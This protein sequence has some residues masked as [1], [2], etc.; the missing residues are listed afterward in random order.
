MKSIISIVSII[1]NEITCVFRTVIVSI[2]SNEITCVFRT[3]IVSIISIISITPACTNSKTENITLHAGAGLRDAADELIQ[4]FEKENPNIKINANY[5]GSGRLLGQII[6]GNLGGLFMPGDVFYVDQAIKKGA[7][8]E[9]TKNKIAYFVPVIFVQKG[10]PK[11]IYLLK[12]LERKNVRIGLGDERIAA[13]GKRTLKIFEKNKI[14][15][16]KIK[17][18][19]VVKTA[20]V[21]ELGIAIAAKTVDVVILW[22]VIARQFT[23]SGDIISI[24]VSENII[25][26]IPIVM[27]KPT[28][29]KSA[30]Q[31]FI[32]FCI[33]KKGKEILKEKGYNVN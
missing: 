23:K 3:V 8:I 18:Q 16:D 11:N 29:N 21:N 31:K 7:A 33:S 24:P 1:S 30:A 12:N 32:D 15:Y 22:D 25:S 20:T 28:V 6:T 13:I 5:A 17:K 14:P 26:E 27:L 9:S 10:N 19:V 2:I 4:V